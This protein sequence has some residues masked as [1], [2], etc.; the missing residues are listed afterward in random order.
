M[1]AKA[2]MIAS[3]KNSRPYICN[4][5]F[6][7][8]VITSN[9]FGANRAGNGGAGDQTTGRALFTNRTG[10]H[11]TV[12]FPTARTVDHIDTVQVSDDG[13]KLVFHHL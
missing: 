12:L 1:S 13:V 11:P 6:C 5:V 10:F 3:A 8:L 4:N 2:M 9:S 7:L